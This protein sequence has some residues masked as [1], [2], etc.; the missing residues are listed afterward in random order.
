M[1]FEVSHPY[2]IE[3]DE[4]MTS[5][6][7]D[8]NVL[9]LA[10]FSKLGKQN[11]FG[12]TLGNAGAPNTLG[13][14][15]SAESKAHFGAARTLQ[16]VPVKGPDGLDDGGHV[17]ELNDGVSEVFLQIDVQDFSARVELFLQVGDGEV[18]PVRPG[19]HGAWGHADVAHVEQA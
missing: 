16:G 13:R 11:F 14:R 9:D 15:K 6:L 7:V 2:L 17:G 12:H 5:A 8:Q 1:N 10:K 18:E 3:I 4:R 19:G